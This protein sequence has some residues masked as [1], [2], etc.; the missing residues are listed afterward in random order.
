M[1]KNYKSEFNIK[2]NDNIDINKKYKLKS[3]FMCKNCN[4]EFNSNNKLHKHLR[5]EC[6][7]KDLNEND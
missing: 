3:L 2:I 5:N 6:Q 4:L 1:F 7:I